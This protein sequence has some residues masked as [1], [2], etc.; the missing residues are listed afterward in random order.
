[1][2][3]CGYVSR[4]PARPIILPVVGA[5]LC[6]AACPCLG[7]Q[8]YTH[9]IGSTP[10]LRPSTFSLWIP[11]LPAAGALRGVLAISDYESGR[12]IY[13]DARFREWAAQ[14]RFA[15][16]RFDLR[17]RDATLNLAKTQPALNRLLNEAMP[18]FA[19]VSSRAELASVN[20]I[21][22][23][24][25]QAGWQAV[26]FAD[27]APER[28]IAVLPIHD[29]TGERAPQQALVT[30]GLGVPAL[31]LVGRNDNVNMGS[32][33]DGTLYSQSIVT[34]VTSRRAA[35]GLV[36]YLIRPN[37]GHTQWEGNQPHG[38]PIMIDWL[39]AVVAL[40]VPPN[41]GERPIALSAND[42]WAGSLSV[43]FNASVPWITANS[44]SIAPFVALDPSI[45]TTRLWLPS[46]GFAMQWHAYLATGQYVP[47][48]PGCP[49]SPAG[50]DVNGDCRF[51]IENP[52][53]ITLNPTD[54]DRDGAIMPEDARAVEYWLR[55]GE[56]VDMSMGRR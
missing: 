11:A 16:L 52:Y 28:T 31:H 41:P 56:V 48:A 39:S 12:Q 50:P 34:F 25:W 55:R 36:S 18:H 49:S 35:G 27:L 40:R 2:G 20:M 44:F 24:L 45:H 30:T 9:S 1:L 32:L 42:G 5:L 47:Y 53:A 54:I 19:G 33:A 13:D 37:T 10:E 6:G 46:S 7:Q 29:S 51:D 4:V 14:S 8:E 43:T 17:S 23:G 22:T 21:F 3:P 15:L 26:A 38:V